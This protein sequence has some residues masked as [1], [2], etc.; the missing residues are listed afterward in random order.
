MRRSALIDR[1]SFVRAAG[2]LFLASLSPRA[3]FALERSDAVFASGF[4]APDGSFGIGLVAEDGT[5]IDRID[6]P[7]RIHGLG[8]SPATGLS[9]AFARRPGTFVVIFD[10]RKRSEPIVIAA[11]SRPALL[12]PRTF[13]AG[14]P[15]A[16]CQRKRF[17]R[18]SRHD[19]HL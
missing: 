2:A 3:L 11:P 9:V 15:A 6:L 10:A 7:D 8:H 13:L 14:R 4:R 16:L 1:R 5:F 19:R 17:R 12:R 18:Q